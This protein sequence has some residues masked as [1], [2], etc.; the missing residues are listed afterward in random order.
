ML[1][2]VISKA[3]LF[4]FFLLSS[5]Y[6]TTLLV[7]AGAT[8]IATKVNCKDSKRGF[9]IKNP[10][11]GKKMITNCNLVQRKNTAYKCENILSVAEKCPETCR[12]CP[13]TPVVIIK[14]MLEDE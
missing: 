11:N 12:R 9:K 4:H 10:E 14:N 8:G 7:N 1:Q 2:T 6:T 3:V 13:T 5:S